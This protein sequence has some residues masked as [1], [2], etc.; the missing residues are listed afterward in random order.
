MDLIDGY[1]RAA[2]HY[3]A[4][5]DATCLQLLL[6]H[7][8]VVNAQDAGLATPLHWASFK[9]NARCVRIL[10]QHGANVN[11][12]DVNSDTPLSWAAHKD[13]MAAINVLLQY[14]AS[15]GTVNYNCF[16]PLLRSIRS[17]GIG[18]STDDACLDVLIKADGQFDVRTELGRWPAIVEGHNQLIELLRPLCQNP[19]SLTQ[20]SRFAIRLRLGPCYLP[21]VVPKLPI[22]PYLQEYVLL[23][24]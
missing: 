7:D 17:L 8:A 3:A 12:L 14:N 11:A 16:T 10:L 5:R 2:I 20:L 9:N 22:P 23:E 15:V 24:R 6:S 4:E 18:L 13:N 21:N 1:G 19:R